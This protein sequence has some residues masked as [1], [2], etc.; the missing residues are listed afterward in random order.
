MLQRLV[1]A[2]LGPAPDRTIERLRQ[3]EADLVSP[4]TR[5][6][7]PYVLEGTGAF[8]SIRP[9]LRG[10]EAEP[11]YNEAI[12]LQPRR[13]LEVGTYRGGCL[14]WWAQAAT[15]DATIVSIGRPQ[16]R[17]GA[18][19][20]T[21]PLIY[22]ADALAQPGQR[23]SFLRS[24]CTLVDVRQALDDT[25]VDLLFLDGEPHAPSVARDFNEYASLV[26]PDGLIAMHRVAA[27]PR[28][29][30]VARLWPQLRNRYE[31]RE[32]VGPD[33]GQGI[34]VLRVPAQGVDPID[35]ADD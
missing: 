29:A 24:T 13:V 6:A 15:P 12:A 9:Q 33:S 22:I 28:H 2:L 20:A 18:D 27:D 26:R 5:F 31:T 10:D 19:S 23:L 32:Y 30:A 25:P 34:G 8:R 11:L 14:Y 35:L 4:R 7:V 3:L 1:H 17:P 21:C 16:D